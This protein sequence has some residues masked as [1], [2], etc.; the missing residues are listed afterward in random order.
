MKVP[1]TRF[2]MIP[3]PHDT[4]RPLQNWHGKGPSISLR[5]MSGKYLKATIGLVACGGSSSRMGTDKSMLIYN[6]KPQRYHVYE[7]LQPFCEKVFI[8]CKKE[9][10]ATVADGYDI[11]TDDPVYNNIGPMA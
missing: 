11:L 6:T 9:Q 7:M 3:H 8:S 5:N 10:S 2:I 4:M 1:T